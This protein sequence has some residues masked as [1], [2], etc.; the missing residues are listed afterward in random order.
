LMRHSSSN[1]KR[2]TIAWSKRR[3][4]SAERLLIFLVWRN[5]IKGQSEKTRGAPTPAMVKGLFDRPLD[6]GEILESRIF[7][8]QMELPPR[9]AEYYE[10]KV[11][12]VPLPKNNQHDLKYAF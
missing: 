4:G 9:W 1:H 6:A 5:Y 2:E 8:S 11:E 3:Q 7:P 12:T 10:K